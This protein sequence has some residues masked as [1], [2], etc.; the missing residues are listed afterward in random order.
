MHNTET[1]LP[2]QTTEVR[3]EYT[4]VPTSPTAYDI[5]QADL[6]MAASIPTMMENMESMRLRI[7]V[8]ERQGGY[9]TI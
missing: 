8:N 4:D 1:S 6:A 2:I 9:R 5:Q 3:S 7:E